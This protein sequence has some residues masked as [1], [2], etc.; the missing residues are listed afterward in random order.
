MEK[1]VIMESS[2]RTQGGGHV[3]KEYRVCPKKFKCVWAEQSG[4]VYFCMLSSC[5]C[6]AISDGAMEW[7]ERYLKE[8][9]KNK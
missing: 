4:D 6:T 9:E 1:H 5:P 8:T 2:R 3:K 7:R